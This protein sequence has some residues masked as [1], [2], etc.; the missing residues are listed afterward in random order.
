MTRKDLITKMSEE[1]G[2]TKK[3]SELAL[4]SFTNIIENSLKNN[5]K[6]QLIGFGTFEVSERSARTGRNPHNGSVIEI[7]SCKVPKFKPSKALK[8]SVH[9]GE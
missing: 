8:S 7:P 4:N 2:L 9:G 3:D 6:I 5:E 1:S